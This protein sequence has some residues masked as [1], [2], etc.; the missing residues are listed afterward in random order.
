MLSPFHK[1]YAGAAGQKPCYDWSVCGLRSAASIQ[2]QPGEMTADVASSSLSYK[3]YRNR[4]QMERIGLLVHLARLRDVDIMNLS[5]LTFV[6]DCILETLMH[7]TAEFI[8]QNPP[9]SCSIYTSCAYTS[10][11]CPGPKLSIQHYTPPASAQAPNLYSLPPQR[12]APPRDSAPYGT[13]QSPSQ[14]QPA[15]AVPSAPPSHHH[16]LGLRF[17][18]LQISTILLL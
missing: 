14:Q 11:S 4:T 17:R 16:Q 9:S 15:Y 12:P 18:T 5:D 6:T 2:F 3:S 1:R 8:L 7:C 13:V 10:S